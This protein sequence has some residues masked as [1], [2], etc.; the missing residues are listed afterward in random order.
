MRLPGRQQLLLELRLTSPQ[1]LAWKQ[2]W[3]LQSFLTWK[4]AWKPWKQP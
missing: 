1:W 4:Q 3:Q 2:P